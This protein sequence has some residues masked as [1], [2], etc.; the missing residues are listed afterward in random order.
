MG[1]P[2]SKVEV[3]DAFCVAHGAA[4]K[5]NQQDYGHAARHVPAFVY[6]IWCHSWFRTVLVTRVC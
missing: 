6:G 3:M 5:V 1:W 2:L 4:C